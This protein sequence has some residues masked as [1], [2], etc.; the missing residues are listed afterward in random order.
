VSRTFKQYPAAEIVDRH[1]NPL[2]MNSAAIPLLGYL[3]PL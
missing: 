3:I 1:E 2:P